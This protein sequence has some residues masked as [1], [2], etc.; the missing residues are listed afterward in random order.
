MHLLLR[1]E[2][3]DWCRSFRRCNKLLDVRTPG[4]GHFRRVFADRAMLFAPRLEYA[5]SSKDGGSH[6][7]P[8]Q[9]L[10]YGVLQCVPLYPLRERNN[11]AN[12]QQDRNESSNPED[13]TH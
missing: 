4:P 10:D 12:Q 1:Q 11:R 2:C 9:S 7:P 5:R 6:R 8:N 13:H 3:P